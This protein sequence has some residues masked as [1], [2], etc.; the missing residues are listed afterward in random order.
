MRLTIL[1][2][3]VLIVGIAVAGTAMTLRV[4][5]MARDESVD[6]PTVGRVSDFTLTE[7]SGRAVTLEDLRGYVW[8]ADFI[9][10]RCSGACPMM[11]SKMYELQEQTSGRDDFRL[12]SFTL[13]PE[14][15]TPEQLE[16]Y[17][18]TVVDAGPRWL[19]LTG[20]KQTL[21]SLSQSDFLLSVTEQ[22]SEV[23]PVLHS[24]KLV[25]VDAQARIRGYYDGTEALELERLLEDIGKLRGGVA[26]GQSSGP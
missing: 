9:F 18:R 19:W 17:S 15:D 13:D 7:R 16:K 22:D 3:I 21:H 12:V 6:L 8:V 20:D 11:A 4:R 14:Y 24:Q 5:S 1:F 2:P 25:L 23:E 26:R 10:T